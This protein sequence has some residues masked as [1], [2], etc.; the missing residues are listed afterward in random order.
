M[1]RTE[2]I[3]TTTTYTGPGN[4]SQTYN[5]C[6]HL[7]PCGLCDRTDRPCPKNG[8]NYNPWEPHWENINTSNSV[9]CSKNE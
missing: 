1:L 8:N 9:E 4:F 3:G 7:L 6:P 2:P 5:L